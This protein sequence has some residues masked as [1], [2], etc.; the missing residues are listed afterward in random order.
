[1]RL[2]NLTS[3]YTNIPV[4]PT[5]LVIDGVNVTHTGNFSHLKTGRTKLCGGASLAEN[6]TNVRLLCYSDILWYDLSGMSEVTAFY[7]ELTPES[8]TSS[9]YFASIT[10]DGGY[11][12]IQSDD[13][14]WKGLIFSIWDNDDMGSDG[15]C[16]Y[17]EDGEGVSRKNFDGEGTGCS[18]R[19]DYEWQV[20]V[21][22]GTFVTAEPSE[23]FTDFSAYFIFGDET[24]RMGVLRYAT[25]TKLFLSGIY[26]FLENWSQQGDDTVRQG[27][28]TNSWA[29]RGTMGHFRDMAEI[30]KVNFDWNH[31]DRFVPIQKLWTDSKGFYMLLDGDAS[32]TTPSELT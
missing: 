31:Q 10:F 30:V 8:E 17:I 20:G 7:N 27:L 18:L 25:T 28:Y 14:G 21:A 26:S 15:V 24:I 19:M 16:L 6:F 3:I 4:K 13:P 29:A 23:G 12:G 9:T 1:M 22:V 32:G 5:T 2:A 11:M